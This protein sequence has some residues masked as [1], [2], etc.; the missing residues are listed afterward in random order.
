MIAEFEA[1]HGIVIF[2][3]PYLLS[4]KCTLLFQMEVEQTGDHEGLKQYYITKIE[5]LQAS[6]IF[7]SAI[8]LFQSLLWE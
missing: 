4:N 1:I 8:L 3:L 7:S 5:E 6:I 2:D